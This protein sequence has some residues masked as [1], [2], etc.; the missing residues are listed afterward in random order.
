MAVDYARI[1]N[2]M[3]KFGKY[4]GDSKQTLVSISGG[5]DSDILVHIIATYFREHLPHVQF[6][7]A[8]TGIEYRATL[9]HLDYL[10]D[11]YDIRIYEVHGTPIP[12]AVR[13]Y[14]TP[15]ISKMASEYFQRLQKHNFQWEDGTFEEL[16]AKY[17]RSKIAV[18]FWSSA[19][20]KNSLYN[21]SRVSGLKEY[22][23]GHKPEFKISAMCCEVSKKRPIYEWGKFIEADLYV[24]GERKAEGGV[25]IGAH[26]SCFEWSNAH[27]AYKFMPLWFWDDETKKYYCEKEGIK[28]S[29]CYTVYGLRRTGCVGCPFARNLWGELEVMKKYE[30]LCYKVCCNVFKDSYQFRR[31]FETYRKEH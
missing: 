3:G 18:R 8:N 4:L 20:G 25:R 17:P 30:P 11:K 15:I 6:V 2:T 10:R 28:H 27:G 21:I 1:N 14:G 5:A 22:L 19:A 16:Y 23:I 24:T 31:D 29:D 26:Q 13:K 7:F 12:L 9:D